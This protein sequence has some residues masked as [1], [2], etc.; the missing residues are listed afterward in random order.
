V[1]VAA[2]LP[3]EL[4]T[5]LLDI[6]RQAFTD[7]LRLTAAISAVLSIAVAIVASILLKDVPS[8]SETLGNDKADAGDKQGGMPAKAQP[9]H[10]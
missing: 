1:G 9:A 5:E 2:Q 8:Q 10:D 7:G 6:A 4:G 3:D